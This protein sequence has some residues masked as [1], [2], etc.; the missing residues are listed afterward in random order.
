M[1]GTTGNTVNGVDIGTDTTATLALGNGADGISITN[2]SNNLIGRSV[3]AAMPI[4]QLAR[5]EL[6]R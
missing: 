3:T 1:V 2:S 6:G 4:A 5:A